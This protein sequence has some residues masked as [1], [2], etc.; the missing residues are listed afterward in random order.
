MESAPCLERLLVGNWW[1]THPV[2]WLY[3]TVLEIRHAPRPRA[4]GYL[5]HTVHK[6]KIGNTLIKA[7]MEVTA[8][9]M[10]S[11]VKVL[12][13]VAGRREGSR[14]V[15]TLLRCFPNLETLYVTVSL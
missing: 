13:A 2:E 4:I 9:D 1:V 7:T 5:N 15:T 8:S 14:V 3:D 10:L 11:E 12:R 6:L